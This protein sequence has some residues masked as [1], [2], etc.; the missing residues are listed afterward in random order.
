MGHARQ[1]HD[2]DESPLILIIDDD[3]PTT[4]LLAKH[5]HAAGY[6]TSVAETGEMG[7]TIAERYV[8]A[9]ILLDCSLD[10]ENG[11]EV[12]REIRSRMQLAD[13]PVIFLTSH[14]RSDGLI[15]RCFEVGATDFVHKSY[16]RV[17]LL[18][19]L[20]V[21]LRERQLRES[22]K[23]LATQ[24]GLTGVSNRRHF[25]ARA[26]EAI[27]RSRQSRTLSVL[28]LVDIDQLAVVNE[29]F[30]H[31]LGDEVIL[32]LSRL[33]KRLA[34]PHCHVG[35]VGGDEL[36]MLLN[37]TT[38]EAALRT[39]DRLRLTLSAIAFDA[40]TSPKHFSAGFGLAQ[41]DGASEAIDVDA[42]MTRAD[43][44]LNAAKEHGWGRL[45]AFWQLDPND[46]CAVPPEKRHAR[47]K[48]R[49]RTHRAFV[50]APPAP[51]DPPATRS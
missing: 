14:D 30:G 43:V 49:K 16:S 31:E 5:L 11:F 50:G 18:A 32:T 24:D 41:F 26:M 7:L 44:A 8:P 23:T 10:D 33:M 1:F 29:R 40:T 4:T 15:E 45:V 27:S 21:T 2:R 48:A 17:E 51:G 19:R 3:T 12:C 25:I 47:R 46:L 37:E 36:A 9:A 13:V 42:W 28:A 22:F 39:C 6:R 34:G 35:R 38:R 20:R